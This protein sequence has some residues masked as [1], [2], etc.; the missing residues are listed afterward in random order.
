MH[1]QPVRQRSVTCTNFDFCTSLVAQKMWF[2]N[3][4]FLVTDSNLSGNNKTVGIFKLNLMLMPGP[5]CIDF[6]V[7]NLSGRLP[8]LVQQTYFLARAKA[9][10]PSR[11]TLAKPEIFCDIEHSSSV[12]GRIDSDWIYLRLGFFALNKIFRHYF[13]KKCENQPLP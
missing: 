10:K 5:F 3:W 2:Q 6:I 8:A 13:R 9:T 1:E 11:A 7:L 12:L 4:D